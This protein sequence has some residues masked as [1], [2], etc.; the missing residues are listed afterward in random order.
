MFRLRKYLVFFF[1]IHSFVVLSQE[2]DYH[3]V[4]LL[5]IENDTIEDVNFYVSKIID[6]RV[7][8]DN[9][10]IAQKGVF[11]RKVLSK[12][13]KPFEEELME[14]FNVVFPPDSKKE[15][16]VIRVNQLLIS[17]KTGAFKETG[18][19]IANLDV[20]SFKDDVY[21]FLESFSGYAEKNSADVTGKHD[22]RIRQVLKNCLM[23]FNDIDYKT[24]PKRPISIEVTSIPVVL[25]EPL[26]KG[27]FTSFSE[28]YANEPFEDSLIKFKDNSH[29]SNKLFLEDRSH[30]RTLYYAYSDGENIYLNASNYSGEKHFVKT[31]LIDK[32]LLFNDAFINQDKATGMSLAFGVLGLLVSNTQ[33]NVLLDLYNGQYYILDNFK[34]RLLLKNDYPELYKEYKKNSND[35][36]L[37][38][39]IL[40][41]LYKG[42]Q[43]GKIEQIL[44]EP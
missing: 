22:N 32:Y 25:N 6:N 29:R 16:L 13:D 41:Q 40:E 43:S 10:G 20:L 5:P 37:L 19:A 1:L 21:Y 8:K 17:E 26:N 27:F 3:I 24:K 4:N 44:K 36:N 9:L 2:S 39:S 23:D 28:L 38:K 34:I 14:Y 30:K 11:N 18:K 31:E 42:G 7:Y 35:V 15:P 33:S 12:F